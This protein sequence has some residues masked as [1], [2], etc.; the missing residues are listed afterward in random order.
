M[1]PFPEDDEDLTQF[2]QRHRSSP[3]PAVPGLEDRIIQSL[4]RRSSVSRPL[5]LFAAGIAAC[6]IGVILAQP[7]RSPSVDAEA[8]EFMESNWSG[9]IE[10]ASTNDMTDYLAF[11]ENN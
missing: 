7:A 3:P 1:K 5:I 8:L 10:G 2:L 9:V 11:V 4:P 6:F